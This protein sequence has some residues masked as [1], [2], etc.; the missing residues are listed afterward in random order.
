[1]SNMRAKDKQQNGF[2]IVELLI[3]IVV[4]GILAAITIVAYNGLQQRGRDTQ[5][6]SD[7][8]QITKALHLYKIDNGSY[9][10]TTSGCASGSSG[11]GNGYLNYV[12]TGTTRSIGG[13]LVENGKLS[14]ELKDPSGS[15]SC[16]GVTCHTYMIYTCASGTY[17]MANLES[18]P[19][20]DTASDGTCA[21]T[22]D[23]SYGIN[24]VIKVS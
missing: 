17:L 13:C 11:G 1:M 7:L 9:P 18:I 12:Y 19:Q 8:S 23:T 16:S 2:T 21:S 15:L 10:S 24:Y 20:D 3:V 5:R 6:K 14:T 22:W 4:I